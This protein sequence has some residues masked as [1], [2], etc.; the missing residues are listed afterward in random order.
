MGLMTYKKDGDY[1]LK[2]QRNDEKN[3]NIQKSNV[4]PAEKLITA[5]LALAA[6]PLES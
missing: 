1:G 4:S 6:C 3:V 2:I 5:P